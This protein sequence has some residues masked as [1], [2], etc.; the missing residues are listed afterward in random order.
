METFSLLRRTLRLGV[1]AHQTHPDH[2]SLPNTEDKLR[3]SNTLSARQLHLLVRRPLLQRCPC[4]R[5]ADW[6][7]SCFVECERRG[8]LVVGVSLSEQRVG[9]SLESLHGVSAPWETEWWLLQ[10]DE[11]Q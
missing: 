10:F 1:A 2:P 6:F 5:S 8:E 9:L 11:L 7:A 4:S 3:A